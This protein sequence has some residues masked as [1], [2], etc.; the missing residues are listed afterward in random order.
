M[1]SCMLAKT[2]MYYLLTFAVTELAIQ[3]VIM[4]INSQCHFCTW[5]WIALSW[6]RISLVAVSLRQWQDH[7]LQRRDLLQLS[8]L[9]LQSQTVKVHG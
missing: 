8:S 7:N 1:I 2:I 6:C 5:V 3:Q 4:G 9:L